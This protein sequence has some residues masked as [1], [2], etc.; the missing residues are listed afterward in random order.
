ML[1][2]EKGEIIGALFGDKSLFGIYPRHGHYK[3]YDYPRYKQGIIR[4]SLGKDEEWG[5]HLSDLVFKA[6]QIKGSVFH[7]GREWI[8][9]VDSTRV[10]K[11]LMR[12]FNPA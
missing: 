6:Y 9:R 5:H 4:I 3:G 2:E 10:V 7:D 1:S 11:D 8:F 12:W